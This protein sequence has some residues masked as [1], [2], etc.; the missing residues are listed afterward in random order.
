MLQV[1]PEEEGVEEEEVGAEGDGVV[2]APGAEEDP[3]DVKKNHL[4]LICCI[5]PCVKFSQLS[6]DLLAGV[7]FQVHLISFCHLINSSSID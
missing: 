7:K 2:V 5:H 1:V 6:S 3:L 4:I